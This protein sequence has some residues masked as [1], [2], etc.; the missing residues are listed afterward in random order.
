[1]SPAPPLPHP[2]RFVC[3]VC[4]W[5]ATARNQFSGIMYMGLV[6]RLVPGCWREKLKGVRLRHVFEVGVV[7]TRIIPL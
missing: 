1:M 7:L 3:D 4:W 6:R 2:P 5:L